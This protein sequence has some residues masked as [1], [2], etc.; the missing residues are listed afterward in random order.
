MNTVFLAALCLACSATATAQSLSGLCILSASH[1]S[2][3]VSGWQVVLAASNC[4]K[5]GDN[6]NTNSSTMVADRWT[7]VSPELLEKD[8]TNLTATLHG[9]AGDLTCSGLVHDHALSGRYDF[10]PSQPF[11]DQMRTLG[12]DGITPQKQLSFLMLD[13]NT[14]WAKQ[15]KDLGVLD[16]S[17]NKLMALRALRVDADYIQGMARAGYPELHAGRLTEMKAVGVT[18]EKAREA[19]EL[20][21]APTEHELIQMSIFHIDRAFVEKMRARGLN[22]LTL[23]KLIKIKIFKVDE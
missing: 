5:G 11:L 13:V 1:H 16:L 6:C 22:D 8:G 2:N 15:L 14:T 9:D 7:G 19:K 3:G 4:D 12:F 17:T 18:P 23:D 10:V 21:F 20:G